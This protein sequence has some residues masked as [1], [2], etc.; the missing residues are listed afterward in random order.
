M[1]KKLQP[2]VGHSGDFIVP[3]FWQDEKLLTLSHRNSDASKGN[4]KPLLLRVVVHFRIL[5][6][7]IPE[8]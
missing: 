5:C 6:V 4:I 2:L 3:M 7:R 8:D 1:F